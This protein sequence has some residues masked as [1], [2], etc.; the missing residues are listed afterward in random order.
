GSTGYGQEFTDAIRNQ[1]GGKPYDSLMMSLEQLLE[2]H[3]Y[4]DRNRMAAL[5][6]SYGGYM[7]NW[8]NGHTDIFKALVN[9]DGMFSTIGTY[10]N[11]EELYFLETEFEGTPFNSEARKNYER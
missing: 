4:I 2:A 11:T 6:P 7:V 5:G 3:P 1:W 10:Y 8:I 9:H